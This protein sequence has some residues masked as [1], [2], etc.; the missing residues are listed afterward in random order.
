[1]D[2]KVSVCLIKTDNLNHME[3]VINALEENA[4]FI[5]EVIYTG[6]AEDLPEV[7]LNVKTLGIESENKAF[8]RNEALKE[9]SQDWVLFCSTATELEDS[10]LEEFLEVLEDEYPQANLVYPNTVK[11]TSD[12]QEIVNNYDNWY[13]KK[14]V[15]LQGLTVEKHLPEWGVLIKKE[16]FQDKLFNEEYKD[17]EFYEFFLRN[18]EAIKPALSEL[19]FVNVYETT[20]FIDTSFGSKIIRD[21]IVNI[22]PLTELFPHLNWENENLAQS[23]AYTMIGDA[24][25]EYHDFYNASDYY[26]KALISFHNQHTLKNLIKAYIE[27]GLFDQAKQIVSKEQGLSPEDIADFSRFINKIESLIREI[28]KKV[29]EGLIDEVLYSLNDVIQVYQ[30]APIYNIAG[31]LHFYKGDL[32]NAY[33][34]FY[35][36]VIINPLEENILRNLSDVAKQIGKEEEVISLINRIL[37]TQETKVS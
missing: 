33:R 21:Q 25:A 24:L 5:E 17:Y 22:Y 12:N 13:D 7:D 30:G 36:A 8:L 35:K 4:E 31:V 19:S 26:R 18:F 16:L 6:S 9:A 14:R 2:R 27:M 32:V 37:S 11:I 3:K 15:I 1:M 28:E 20:S 10:T 29:E 34:F 23:T